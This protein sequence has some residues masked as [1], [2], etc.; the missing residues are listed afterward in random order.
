M[1]RTETAFLFDLDGTLVDSVYQHVLAWRQALDAEGIPL[2]VWRIHRK[3]GMSGGLFAN[4]LFRETGLAPEEGQLER[5]RRLHAENY[6]RLSVDVRPLPGA[7]E[8]LAWLT[9]S[10][11]PW[12]IAT[13][14]RIETAGPVIDALGVDRGRVPVI[15]RDLV[16]YAKPDPDLFL[17]AAEALGVPIEMST[18][19]G[20]AVWDMLAARRARSLG[21]GLLSGGY[22]QEELERAGAY[23]VFEDPAELLAHIDEVGGRR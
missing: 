9:E 8:L 4:M 22:G 17:A 1:S 21:I 23:R 6:R 18:V 5:L 15:T 7:R 12:A 13:S 14:G 10:E 2:S 19:V 16:K 20:D 3:I 11:I